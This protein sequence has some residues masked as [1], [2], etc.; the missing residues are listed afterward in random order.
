MR[1]EPG[2]CEVGV[3]SV[4][5]T[6]F[7]RVAMVKL[8]VL[9]KCSLFTLSDLFWWTELRTGALIVLNFDFFGWVFNFNS[10]G[11]ILDLKQRPI[12]HHLNSWSIPSTQIPFKS[13]P[14]KS[15]SFISTLSNFW[16]S[17]YQAADVGVVKSLNC[18][19]FAKLR[20]FPEGGGFWVDLRNMLDLAI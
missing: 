11:W 5:A 13:G 12:L 20:T 9:T 6:H 10:F 14:E 16:V 2:L 15:L 1:Q 4:E 7:C 18:W 8:S 3:T 19:E 17:L